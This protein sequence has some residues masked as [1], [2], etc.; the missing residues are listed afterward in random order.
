MSNIVLS[1]SETVALIGALCDKLRWTY[2]SGGTRAEHVQTALRL[3][4]L[5]KTLPEAEDTA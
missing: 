5:S 2:S 3:V 4:E 1:T